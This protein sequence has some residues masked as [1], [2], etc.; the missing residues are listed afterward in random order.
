M[1]YN[2]LFSVARMASYRTIS[3]SEIQAHKLYQWNISLSA[4]LYESLMLLEVAL[5]NVIDC[6]LRELNEILPD[7]DGTIHSNSW[8]L[9][10][11]YVIKVSISGKSIE[12]AI[13][14]A[15]KG[16]RMPSHDDVLAQMT[17]GNRRFVLPSN[18]KDN[19]TRGILW[20]GG[21][22]NVFDLSNYS[23]KLLVLDIKELNSLRNRIAHGE[24]ILGE[25]YAKNMMRSIYR[26]AKSIDPELERYINKQRPH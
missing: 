7:P 16:K 15:K 6:K 24:P 19:Y 23:L 22:K 8:L 25:N 13:D 18:N 1:D 14:R 10:T 11:N 12:S 26:V 20:E 9:D 21:I 4:A 2:K 17:F 3:S 5:R